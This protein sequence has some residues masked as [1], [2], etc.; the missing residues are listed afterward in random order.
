MNALVIDDEAQVR[1]FVGT[2]LADEGWTVSEAESAEQAF[3]MLRGLGRRLLR[4]GDGWREWFQCAATVQ[5]RVA[6]NE[7]GVN[8]GPWERGGSFGCY[9]LW[10][11]RLSVEAVWGGS[12][13]VVIAGD[14]RASVAH[15]ATSRDGIPG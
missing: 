5:G 11:L 7:S 1:G 9:S 6:A 2:V 13:A 14:A 15:A 3:E 10:C 12:V 8:D 4:C